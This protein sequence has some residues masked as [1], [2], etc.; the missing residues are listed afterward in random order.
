MPLCDQMELPLDEDVC[1][2]I[3]A[4]KRV[5]ARQ[6]LDALAEQGRIKA[7]FAA[8][9]DAF[10]V[11]ATPT[12]GTPAIPLDHVDQTAT[13]GGFTRAV[14]LIERC[15]LTVPNGFTEEGLPSGLHLI[16]RPY[17]AGTVLRIRWAYEQAT[18]WHNR[19]PSGLLD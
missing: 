12:V 17:D 8:A 10:D 14:N 16:G 11:L 19:I 18:D 9:L 15:A 4:G 6:C 7:Q 13:R 3:L 1:P 5:S 2:R